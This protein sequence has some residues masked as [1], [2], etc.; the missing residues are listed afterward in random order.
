MRINFK[1]ILYFL[2]EIALTFLL[3]QQNIFPSELTFISLLLT[4]VLGMILIINQQKI[5]FNPYLVTF[6][7]FIFILFLNFFARNGQTNEI[8]RII[9]IFMQLL[10]NL[11]IYNYLIQINNPQ[12]FMHLYSIIAVISL[13]IIIFLVGPSNAVTSRLGHNGS[14]GIIS[15]YIFNT[16]IYKSSNGT[17]NFC[18][19]AVLFFLYF[20]KYEKY[21]KLNYI[22]IILLSF[23]IILCGSR[24]GILTLGIFILYFCFFDK[25]GINFKKITLL[26]TIPVISFILL[27]K[28]P[29]IYN[30]IGMRVE[31][32]VLNMTNQE[33]KLDGNSYLMR[34]S[35][36]NTALKWI[37]EKPFF[38]YGINVFENK[39]GYGTE[40]NLLQILVETG[41]IGAVTYYSF[42]IPLIINIIKNKRK[43]KIMTLFSVLIITMLIQDYGSVTYSWQ[44][45]TVWY[46]VFFAINKNIKFKNKDNI[47][48]S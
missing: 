30:T 9:L 3:L 8:N 29:I 22:L 28:V 1:T 12:R 26:A 39:V 31:S 24:K 21:S 14:G 33:N 15:Y 11:C 38:G 35:L 20:I 2:F 5:H 7:L 17:A 32:M 13:I 18:A 43:S 42:L 27:F 40:N 25:K 6:L 44:H 23:G 45:M 37:N 16:P 48:L 4:I 41:I 46:S 47:Y 19:I 36:T 34:E 10:S